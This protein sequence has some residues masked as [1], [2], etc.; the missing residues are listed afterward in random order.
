MDHNCGQAWPCGL[1]N[2]RSAP[3]VQ[4]QGAAATHKTYKM[5][6][7]S[8]DCDPILP[9]FTVA[10]TVCSKRVQLTLQPDPP[11]Q[12]VL[13]GK[14]LPLGVCPHFLTTNLSLSR[15]HLH[16][17][18]LLAILGRRFQLYR[19]FWLRIRFNQINAIGWR[20]LEPRWRLPSW[21]AQGRCTWTTIGTTR[22]SSQ[23]T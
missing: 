1:T 15:L 8:S 11:S 21:Q 13:L 23:M 12:L 5:S 9:C 22:P 7:T 4:Q 3:Q 17:L 10:R 18:Y 14:A 16:T 20:C 19:N 6:K 2:G